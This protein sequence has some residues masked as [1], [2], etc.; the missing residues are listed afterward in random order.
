VSF[1][2]AVCTGLYTHYWVVKLYVT[3][4][5]TQA[6]VVVV[7]GARRNSHTALLLDEDAHSDV[8]ISEASSSTFLTSVH[9][10]DHD[11]PPTASSSARA[12]SGSVQALR[13]TVAAAAAL[14]QAMAHSTA[15]SVSIENTE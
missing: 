11:V 4:E 8:H 15:V 10:S 3:T 2:A 13:T 6:A 5:C 9:T 14:A 1:F 7:S 12:V